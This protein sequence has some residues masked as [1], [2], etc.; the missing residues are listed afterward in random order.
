MLARGEAFAVKSGVPAQAAAHAVHFA[1]QIGAAVRAVI[2]Q[3]ILAAVG[4]EICHAD[5]GQPYGHAPRE[6][7]A[8]Q[9]L[10]GDEQFAPVVGGFAEPHRLVCGKMVHITEVQAEG[11]RLLAVLAQ[12]PADPLAEILDQAAE[13]FRVDGAAFNGGFARNGFRRR[14][15]EHFAAVEAASAPA[16]TW[17]MP[18]S[19]STGSGVRKDSS[20]PGATMRKPCGR[21]S[22]EAI[23]ATT[24]VRAAPSETLNRVRLKI[25]A[26]KRR[27]VAS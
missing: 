20:S 23:E 12:G 2:E 10:G 22:R 25:S 17:Q 21:P 18:W 7:F 3:F 13:K 15:H 19:F 14:K 27:S 5:P 6:Q 16:C 8:E 24:F 11:A 9:F 4:F 26:C 1:V